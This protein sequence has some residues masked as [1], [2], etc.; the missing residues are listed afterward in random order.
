[1]EFSGNNPSQFWL[2][3][4]PQPVTELA[5]SALEWPRLLSLVGGFASSPV[6]REWVAALVPSRDEEWLRTQHELVAEMQQIVAAGVSIPLAGLFNPNDLIDKSNIPGAALESEELR[7]LIA[8]M[9]DL[10]G[11]QGLMK[12]PPADVDIPA[13]A[14]LSAPM[15]MGD[16]RPLLEML[17]AKIMPDGTLADNA[18]PELRRIRQE[19][20]R[21]QRAIEESLRA[22]LRKLSDGGQTQEDLITIR[23]DRFVIPVKAEQKR[24]ISGVVHGASSSGQTVYVEPLE[25]IEE[26][27]ELVRLI[28]EE[29]AEIHRIFVA[30]ARQIATHSDA[31]RSGARVLA[32]VDSLLARARFGREYQCTRPSFDSEN[33]SLVEARHPLLE[34]RLRSEGGKIIPLTLALTGSERQLILSGPNTGGK[35]VALKTAALLAMMA[36]SG[37][38]VPASVASFPIFSGFLADIGD[39]QSIEQG[40]SAFSAHIVNLDRIAKIAGPES[41]VLLDELGSATDPEEGAAL[42]VAIAAYFLERKTWAILS[43]H[44]TSLKVFGA[45]T[46]GVV[47]A[48]VGVEE[49]TL[50]PNY[51]LRLGVPGISAGIHTAERLGL[52]AEIITAARARLGSQAVDIARFLDELHRQ[53]ELTETRHRQVLL[54]EAETAKLKEKLEREGLTE[55]HNRT[56]EL[57]VKLNTLLKDFEYQARE[58]VKLVEDRAQQ[59]KLS[60]EAERRIARMRREFQE[61]FNS[62]VVAHNTGADVGDPNATPHIIRHVAVGDTVKLRKLGKTGQV[63]RAIDANFFEIAVGP[64]K[65]RVSRNDLSEVTPAPVV[66]APPQT[67]LRAMSGRRGITVQMSAGGDADSL[68]SEI[69]VI[70]RNAEEAREEV[71]RYLDRAFLAGLPRIRIVH[72]T[73]MGVLRRTLRQ[74][75]NS[76]PQ[77]ETVTEP[78]QNEGGAGATVVELKQ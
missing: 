52:A 6:G 7:A 16:L 19:Q 33:L 71:E 61:S 27:N 70:G 46:P 36:Q 13:L 30:L 53:L 31:I 48:A 72:G 39:A 37:I 20:L 51:T 66:V 58:T 15:M 62:A 69:N 22:A 64:M 38:P 73:G 65:M 68:S 76:H 56:R 32:V 21:Q 60:K 28:E 9:N 78:P 2:E 59:Q 25:T 47:N 12:S 14:A 44:H 10:S 35:T 29:Q 4:I 34:K 74:W 75:L 40:L 50:M 49:V 43:T 3:A 8:L 57:E 23:G 5:S 26:N 55:M 42:A 24:R 17:A 11:W 1:M 77:V 63:V 54:R 18:S 41:L 67:P 45:N